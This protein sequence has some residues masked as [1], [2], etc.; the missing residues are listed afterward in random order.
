MKTITRFAAVIFAAAILL[1]L[2]GCKKDADPKTEEPEIVYYTVSF[3]SDGAGEV[4]SQKVEKGKVVVKPADPTKEGYGSY[5]WMNGEEVFDFTSTVTSDLSLKVKW[6]VG[7]KK[8][9]EAKAV[10]DI[11]FEDNSAIPYTTELTLSEEQKKNV[12]AVIFYAGSDTDI[13]GVRTLGMG[14]KQPDEEKSWVQTNTVQGYDT[15]IEGLVCESSVSGPTAIT[16]I[17]V[18]F[19]GTINGKTSLT[20]L[21]NSVSDYSA[22][23]YPAWGWVENYGITYNLSEANREG[24]YLPSIA[25]LYVLCKN[26][27]MMNTIITSVG[28]TGFIYDNQ[29]DGDYGFYFTST[30]GSANNW[31]YEI[32]FRLS[33]ISSNSG[34]TNDCH[35]CAIREF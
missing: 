23:N 35:V 11:V 8:P 2:A 9:N 10:K 25:E 15:K 12:I 26:Q 17:D 28:G 14:V 3:D 5:D 24:W 19:T 20:T 21:K 31:N 4:E 13:L 33:E 6:Y 27:N 1:G 7:T 16:D 30:Q 32:G 29:E 34:K 22:E 18:T